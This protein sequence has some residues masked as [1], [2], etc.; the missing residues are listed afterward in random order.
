MCLCQWIISMIH[1]WWNALNIVCSITSGQVTLSCIRKQVEQTSMLLISIASASVPA[2]TF[3]N[4]LQAI[5]GNKLFPPQVA[6]GNW[7]YHSNKKYT[8]NWRTKWCTI[9]YHV[10]KVCL[11]E[12]HSFFWIQLSLLWMVFASGSQPATTDLCELNCWY[13]DIADLIHSKQLFLNSHILLGPINLLLPLV[14]GW[15]EWRLKHWIP[16]LKLDFEKYRPTEGPYALH[17]LDGQELETG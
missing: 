7:L 5:T 17:S 2:M 15:L 4:G 10:V 13:S 3:I 14:S 12:P 6:F 16:L 11:A 8:V 1:D 9:Q